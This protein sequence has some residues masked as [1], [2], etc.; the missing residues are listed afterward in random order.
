MP[1]FAELRPEVAK[2]DRYYI[3]TRYPNG[4]PEG[5]LPGEAFDRSDAEAAIVVA[6]KAINAARKP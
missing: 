4:L 2:L 5:G 1:G 6:E 3:P